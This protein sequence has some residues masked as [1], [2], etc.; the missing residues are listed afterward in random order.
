MRGGQAAG[1]SGPAR[2][3]CRGPY[4]GAEPATRRSHTGGSYV[5]SQPAQRTPFN[6]EDSM[7]ENTNPEQQ[8]DIEAEVVAHSEDEELEAGCIVNGSS[9]LS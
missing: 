2:T 8:D 6:K 9:A 5:L 1:G 7:P 4:T 3:G